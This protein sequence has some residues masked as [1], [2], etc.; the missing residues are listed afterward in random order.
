MPKKSMLILTLFALIVSVVMLV[1]A[2]FNVSFWQLIICGF[3]AAWGPLLILKFTKQAPLVDRE[4]RLFQNF[5]HM[6]DSPQK[7]SDMCLFSASQLQV[8]DDE[9][10]RAI[11]I[12]ADAI[13]ALLNGFVQIADQSRLQKEM[14]ESLFKHTTDETTIGFE[15]FVTE[16]SEILKIFVESIVANSYTAMGLVDQMEQ[17]G[18][19]VE[20]VLGVLNEIE[21]IVQ[22]TNLLALNA[23]IEAARAGEAGRGFAVVADEVRSL[24]MRTNHFSRQIRGNIRQIYDSVAIAEKAIMKLASQD[25]SKSMQSKMQVEKTMLSIGE[26]NKNVE[27]VVNELAKI[28][29]QIESGVSN[30]V[31]GLQFQDLV[32]QILLHAKGRVAAQSEIQEALALIYDYIANQKNQAR[33]WNEKIVEFQELEE[34]SFI[35]ADAM[36]SNPVAQESMSTGGVDLF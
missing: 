11:E 1:I 12:F 22:Q 30:A 9:I 33:A 31:R 19:V 28:A 27:S 26:I 34:R 17:V 16:T 32:N 18:K 8:A 25:M 15:S 23:A 29:V 7:Q 4:E 13:P 24:S 35:L 2:W 14:A 20:E 3:V 21:S 10:K 6:G 36:H 5:Q